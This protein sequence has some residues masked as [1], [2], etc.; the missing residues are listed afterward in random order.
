[1]SYGLHLLVITTIYCLLALSLDLSVGLTGLVAISHGALFGI[2]AYVAANGLAAGLDGFSTLLLAS[3]SGLGA[4]LLLALTLRRLGGDF[5][6][7]ASFALQAAATAAFFNLDDL[8]GGASGLQ[9]FGRLRF[10]GHE[11]ASDGWILGLSLLAIGVLSLMKTALRES[12]AGRIFATLQEDEIS[13][14]ALGYDPARL[15]VVLFAAG[16]GFAALAGAL[17][18][19]Y[20]GFLNPIPFGVD[21][22]IGI[23]ACV[24]LGGAGTTVGPVVGACIFILLPELL[25]FV[26]LPAS[27]AANVRAILF[28]VALI[29]A[30]VFFPSGLLGRVAV[31][32][33]RARAPR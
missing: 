2:G 5:F 18:A 17:Y 21:P 25:R 30:M 8:T 1:M 12:P 15:R 3:A 24:V 6:A 29:L 23:L 9:G 19:A 7:V 31:G 28:G 11:A 16:A 4:G 22:A 13:V 27:Q 14:I 10:F 33:G 26:G 20:I 32:R